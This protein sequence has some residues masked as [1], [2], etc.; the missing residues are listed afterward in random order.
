MPSSTTT[1]PGALRPLAGLTGRVITPDDSTYDQTRAVFYGGIEKRP[2]VIV[3]VAHVD[4][5]RRVVNTARGEGFELA[6]RSGGHSIV[7]HS[8]TGGGLVIDLREMSGLGIGPS[9]RTRG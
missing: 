9:E 2:S 1:L 7:G 5:I 3:R 8:T 4:D 6:V